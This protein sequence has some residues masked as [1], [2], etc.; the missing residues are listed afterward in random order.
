[1]KITLLVEGRTEKAFLPHLR[2]FLQIRLAE[3]M[4]NL[5]PAPYNGRI[6]TGDKLARAVRSLLSGRYPSDHVIAL[7]DVYTGMNPPDF[8]DAADAK[9]KMRQWVGNEPRFH[10]H[11]AQYDFEAWLLPYWYRIQ[12]LAGH[13][14]TVPS[15]NPEQVNHTNPPSYHIKQIF[16]NGSCRDDYVKPRDASRILQDEDLSLAINQCGEL[17]S[18]V[19]SIL[20]AC[21]CKEIH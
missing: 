16:R 1:M 6:P 18:L 19:N 5:D 9:S 7:T 4:P 8:S 10:P 13:N 2:K 20:R 15:G 14:R 12:Q 11:V 3:N 21:D 17:K